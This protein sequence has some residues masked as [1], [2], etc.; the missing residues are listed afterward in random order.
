MLDYWKVFSATLNKYTMANDKHRSLTHIHFLANLFLNCNCNISA[1]MCIQRQCAPSSLTLQSK[2]SHRK[3]T[4]TNILKATSIYYEWLGAEVYNQCADAITKDVTKSVSIQRNVRINKRERKVA[5]KMHFNCLATV[6]QIHSLRNPKRISSVTQCRL[7][8]Q[9]W[10]PMLI[11]SCT[12]F[13]RSLLFS[14]N[15]L[16]FSSLKLKV[17][18]YLLLQE[19]NFQF[20]SVLYLYIIYFYFHSFIPVRKSHFNQLFFRCGG[21]W[22]WRYSLLS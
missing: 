9:S 17:V 21:F 4:C 13:C 12:T 16:S 6:C 10:S 11:S 19:L 20:Q 14:F 3:R 5:R 8:C 15:S 2:I 22:N 7:S 18:K 1:N